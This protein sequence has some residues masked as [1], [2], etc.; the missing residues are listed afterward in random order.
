MVDAAYSDQRR[1]EDRVA[2]Y[3]RHLRLIL[4]LVA[5]IVLI[6]G[7]WMTVWTFGGSKVVPSPPGVPTSAATSSE[8]L[9]ETMKD[10]EATQ[11]EAIDQLQVVQ[12][13]LAAQKAE[14]KKLSEQIA[15]VTERLDAQQQSVAKMPAAPS[16]HAAAPPP[17]AKSR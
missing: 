10:L 4:T 2:V 11:Q 5:A 1:Q 12:D 16:T 17:P 8:E 15:T 14:M 3:A 9:L 7:G 13:Q 6:G